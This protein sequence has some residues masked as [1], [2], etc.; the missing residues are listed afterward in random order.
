M[1][2]LVGPPFQF[3]K[4][5]DEGTR[6]PFI[7]RIFF[8]LIHFRD[9]VYLLGVA[10]HELPRAKQAFDTAFNPLL[11]AAQATRDA[12]RE[13][14]GLV[15][16]HVQAIGSGE[17]VR[18]RPN[19]Y[20]ILKSINAPLSQAFDKLV[21]Q[22]IVATKGALQP[23]LRE[24]LDLDIGFF[25]QREAAFS[26]GVA[27]LSSRGEKPFSMYLQ[28]ARSTWHAELQE[29]RSKHEHER[30]TLPGLKY[31]LVADHQVAVRI[32]LIL[33]LPVH[34]YAR[35]TANRV[36][37]FIEDTVLYAMLRKC[38]FPL[39]LVE[40]PAGQRDLDNPKRFRLAPRG[41]DSSP[42]WEIY[43]GESADFV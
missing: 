15:S 7:A 27:R 41:L 25:F 22:S 43:Y 1:G 21:D 10:D 6:S 40:I 36:L 13:I 23:F 5:S 9:Q 24:I 18:F 30:W 4:V 11:E 2:D 20:E 17:A 12:A 29:L 8:G 42:P 31:T 33:N 38:P 35:A 39:F 16:T 3:V 37:R 32:P 34:E 26:E 14:L 19:Q 28:T